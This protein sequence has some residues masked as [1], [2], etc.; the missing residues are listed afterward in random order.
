MSSN[1]HWNNG[2]PTRWQ[3]IF[4]GMVALFACLIVLVLLGGVLG[5]TVKWVLGWFSVG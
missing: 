4:T 3:K 2:S 5:I 1:E